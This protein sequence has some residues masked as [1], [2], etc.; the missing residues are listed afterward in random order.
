MLPPF[1]KCVYL[2]NKHTECYFAFNRS[3]YVFKIKYL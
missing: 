3:I 2:Y 1:W